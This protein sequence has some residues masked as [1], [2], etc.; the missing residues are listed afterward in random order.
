MDTVTK[1]AISLLEMFPGQVS[2]D[3]QVL[4]VSTKQL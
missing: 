3:K 1:I 2:E 4:N